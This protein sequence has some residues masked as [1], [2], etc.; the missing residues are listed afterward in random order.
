MASVV[1]EVWDVVAQAS[2]GSRVPFEVGR[3]DRARPISLLLL[4]RSL[5]VLQRGDGLVR[6]VR[7]VGCPADALGGLRD[8]HEG[9]S[10]MTKDFVAGIAAGWLILA[11]AF[12]LAHGL[13]ESCRASARWLL[14]AARRTE[15]WRAKRAIAVNE[16]LAGEE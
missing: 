5:P 3:Y 11:V 12:V 14:A 4:V 13:P 7:L 9:R 8:R 10:D 16:K 15:D 1:V 6:S 2:A